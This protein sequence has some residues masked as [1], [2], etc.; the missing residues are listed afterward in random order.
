MAE[1][2]A[3]N[4][5]FAPDEMTDAWYRPKGIIDA[6][7][8]A[9]RPG[10]DAVYEIDETID[11]TEVVPMIA[12]PFSPGNAFAA[13]DVAR[14]RLTFDKALIGSC[15]NGSYDD[16]LTAALVVRAARASGI[17][18]SRD[19]ARRLSRVRRRGPAD[20]AAGR[21]AGRRVDRR[22]VPLGRRP[23]PPVVVR[24]V[25]RPGTGRAGARASARSRRS[26]AT[27]RTGWA[28]A[29]KATWRAPP[30]SPPRRS[31]ATWHRQTSSGSPGMPRNSGCD[32]Q[33]LGGSCTA[34][35]AWATKA[36]MSAAGRAPVVRAASRPPAKTAMVGIERIP[37]R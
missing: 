6:A 36:S 5:I 25:L 33:P 37:N 20:R 26:T 8:P 28:S 15:T 18:A 24:T 21:A 17:D 14:E 11:L 27:G 13:D 7:V 29:A 32:A 12:K 1:A 9:L 4:G 35:A 16:L 19:R 31:S 23:D 30:S 10:A 34:P 3:Q 2:E 22:G